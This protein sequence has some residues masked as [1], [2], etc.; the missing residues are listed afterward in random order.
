MNQPC[1]AKLK[2]TELAVFPPKLGHHLQ[3]QLGGNV[4]PAHVGASLRC[5]VRGLGLRRQPKPPLPL[6]HAV[7]QLHFAAVAGCRGVRGGMPTWAAGSL[8]A[9]RR[10]QPAQKL[11]LRL[12]G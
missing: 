9:A 5:F 12:R 7:E 10:L 2:Q 6:Q 4:H 8:P 11:G 3:L 1:G